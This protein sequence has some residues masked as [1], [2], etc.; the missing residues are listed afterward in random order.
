M[1]ESLF[2]N[3]NQKLVKKWHDEHSHIVE[4][5]TKIIGSYEVN[6]PIKAKKYMQELESLTIGHL[7]QEDIAFYN[8][9][10]DSHSIS[11]ETEK[12]IKEFK[13]SFKGVKVALMNFL[14]KYSHKDTP[15]DTEFMIAFKEIVGTVAGRINYE[16]KNLYH[17][18]ADT[19]E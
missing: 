3:N 16:E 5:A 18:L 19:N 7:M 12:H 14:K 6:E 15:L 17:I 11:K 4:L 1:F 9:L 10:K 8:L 2:M 13:E